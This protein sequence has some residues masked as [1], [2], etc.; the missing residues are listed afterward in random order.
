V[1]IVTGVNLSIL[2]DFVFHRELPLAALVDRL[3]DKGRTG[4]SGAYTEEAARANRAVS[5]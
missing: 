2:L 1:A 4:I 5:C 3:V